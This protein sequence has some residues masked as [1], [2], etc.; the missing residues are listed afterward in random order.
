MDENFYEVLDVSSDAH[1]SEIKRAYIMKVRQ[2][3][4]ELYPE[5]F[6]K[7]RKAYETLSNPASR[8]EYDAMSLYGEEIEY[9]QSEATDAIDNDDFQTAI[10]C[11]KKILMIEPSLLHIRN[12]YAMALKYSG[13]YDKAIRQYERLLE[14]DPDSAVY[15]Y[16]LAKAY[17]GKE[18][19]HQAIY[20]YKKAF[21]IDPNDINIIFSIVDL[22]VD[23]R[24]FS[25]A[26]TV[27]NRAINNQ[28]IEG[29]QQ[30][31]YLFKHS[32]SR[33][34]FKRFQCS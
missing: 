19:V 2:F 33:Y 13:E 34:F 31:T 32:A 6:K 26:L 27:I 7:I 29:F 14:I 12:Q 23:L 30:F 1:V 3:P 5:V 18:D 24:E 21:E 22:Y 4:N 16:N 10:A 17:E 15:T 8:T 11:Y 9:L 28:S 25:N 20:F